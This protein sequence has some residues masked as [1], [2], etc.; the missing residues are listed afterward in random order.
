MTAL[1]LQT[2]LLMLPAYFIGAAL[3]CALRKM[4]VPAE[5]VAATQPRMAP[6]A[7]VVPLTQY[8]NRETAQP[9]VQQPVAPAVTPVAPVASRF[10]DLSIGF[11]WRRISR[12]SFLRALQ[13]PQG[14]AT[15]FK[16]QGGDFRMY[17]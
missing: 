1:L 6:A 11:L 8:A 14:L 17:E 9:R 15:R 5:A 12:Q 10:D 16:T 2:L 3:A 7:P 13:W 4:L